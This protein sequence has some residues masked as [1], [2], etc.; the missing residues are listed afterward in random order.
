MAQRCCH[1][2]ACRPGP[3]R[4]SF[5]LQLGRGRYATRPI[6]QHPANPTSADFPPTHPNIDADPVPVLLSAAR[7]LCASPKTEIGHQYRS[8][9]HRAQRQRKTTRRSQQSRRE[10]RHRCRMM[11]QELSC[12][13]NQ[14]HFQ[15]QSCANSVNV[16]CAD[17]SPP[18]GGRRTLERSK[19]C[20]EQRCCPVRRGLLGL[21]RV[22]AIL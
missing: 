6:R 16:D 15:S 21:P 20:H 12:A 18:F 7:L 4:L 14:T 11:M 8:P 1:A 13:L 19:L 9:S 2:R 5:R 3:P 10:R 22:A 17:L